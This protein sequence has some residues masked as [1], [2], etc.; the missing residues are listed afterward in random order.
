MTPSPPFWREQRVFITGA[1]SGIGKA[2]AQHLARQGA[3]LGLLARRAPLLQDL[4][5]SLPLRADEVAWAVADVQDREALQEAVRGLET[6]LGPCDVMI[7]NAG[8]YRKTEVTHFDTAAANAVIAT[9][10]QGVINSI[11]AV[12]PGMQQRGSGHLVA[13]SSM[14][15]MLGL[16]SAGVYCASKAALVTLFQSLR[17]DLQRY[18][19]KATVVCPGYVDTPMITDAERT[20]LKDIITAEHAAQRICH[21]IQRN[22]ATDWFPWHTWAIVRLLSL[23]PSGVYRWAMRHMP[24]MEEAPLP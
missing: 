17:V 16:P 7:A 1:S 21:A 18:G 24:E 8:I 4:A 23:A 9:N 13:V 5:T 10:V 2:L 15:A 20:T 22:R 12:L 14:A 11:G 19:V 3:K 6:Q